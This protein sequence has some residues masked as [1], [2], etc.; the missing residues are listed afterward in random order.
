MSEAYIRTLVLEHRNGAHT[1]KVDVTRREN[2]N[3]TLWRKKST[4][5]CELLRFNAP[6]HVV[7]TIRHLV[8]VTHRGLFCY[9]GE[10][11]CI[12]KR[13]SEAHYPHLKRNRLWEGTMMD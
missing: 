3:Y 5:W 2:R 7:E 11:L 12:T 1:V 8:P 10:P 6:L 9:I 4:G 13:N